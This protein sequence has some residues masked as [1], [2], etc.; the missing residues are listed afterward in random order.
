[1]SSNAVNT[2]AIA[3]NFIVGSCEE[4]FIGFKIDIIRNTVDAAIDVS[5]LGEPWVEAPHR[6]IVELCLVSSGTSVWRLLENLNLISRV[7]ISRQIPGTH[8]ETRHVTVDT[9]PRSQSRGNVIRPREMT[10]SG[11]Q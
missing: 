4:H 9:T 10:C 6:Q 2:I 5:E 11:H 1:M 7:D 8:V 3:N